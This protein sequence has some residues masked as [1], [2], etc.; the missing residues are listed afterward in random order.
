MILAQS[1]TLWCDASSERSTRSLVPHRQGAAEV[2]VTITGRESMLYRTCA[3]YVQIRTSLA[4]TI[5]PHS[6]RDTGHAPNA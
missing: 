2:G 3:R 5:T 4:M 1:D 6:V